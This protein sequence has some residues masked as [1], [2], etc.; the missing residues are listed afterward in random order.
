MSTP[1]TVAAVVLV[2]AVIVM[3]IL[4]KARAFGPLTSAGFVL[5]GLAVGS[6]FILFG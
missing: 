2:I 3:G 5:G 6:G 1:T 4:A